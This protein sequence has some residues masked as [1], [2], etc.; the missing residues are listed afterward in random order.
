MLSARVRTL[1]RK[2]WP[3]QCFLISS[4]LC[5]YV[6]ACNRPSPH[7]AST[8]DGPLVADRKSA[9]FGTVK[10]GEHAKSEITLRN[11]GRAAVV[12]LSF[13]TSCPCVTVSPASATIS[14]GE[15]RRFTVSYAPE[16]G[17]DF[18]GDLS[19]ELRGKGDGD[20]LV[21]LGFAEIRIE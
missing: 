6:Y 8:A 16:S 21:F 5:L 18:R 10:R 7:T 11:P 3:V 2:L 13:E 12:I 20:K 19:A 15:S 14:A 17:E 9:S 1:V 4:L